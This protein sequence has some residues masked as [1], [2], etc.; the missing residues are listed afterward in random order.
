MKIETSVQTQLVGPHTNKGSNRATCVHGHFNT[1]VATISLLSLSQL[2]T[3]TLFHLHTISLC[4]THTHTIFSILC[5]RPNGMSDEAALLDFDS[6]CAKD[7]EN[8]NTL[9]H[10]HTLSVCLSLSLS[11]S[12]THTHTHTLFFLYLSHTH[13]YT[14]NLQR[15]RRLCEGWDVGS[16]ITEKLV[17][18]FRRKIDFT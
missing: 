5:G 13:T 11:L 3:H 17:K 8:E 15:K 10:T 2:L 14:H 12:H 6:I 16:D 18:H 7:F 1:D 4:L 9:T